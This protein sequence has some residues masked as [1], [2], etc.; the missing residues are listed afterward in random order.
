MGA[1]TRRRDELRAALRAA[2]KKLLAAAGSLSDD[3][4]RHRPSDDGWSAVEILAHLIDVDRHWLR[5][6]LAIAA[7]P[8]HVFEHFD[9]NR[10]KQEN[11]GVRHHRP[12]VVHSQL[13]ASH[14]EV[15][16]TIAALTDEELG[17]SGIHPRGHVYTVG[18]VFGR[19]DDHDEAH[20][21]QLHEICEMLA[22]ERS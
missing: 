15:I 13:Q 17:R 3:D 11:T 16:A 8:A 2:R 20:A 22:G 19:Y 18:D 5:Q 1:Q 7:G 14:A 21:R 4:L 10:W 6:A 9:D 12:S